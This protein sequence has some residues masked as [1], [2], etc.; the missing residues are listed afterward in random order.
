VHRFELVR[1]DVLSN[2]DDL[3]D[4]SFVSIDELR[5]DRDRLEM[6]SQICLDALYEVD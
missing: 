6:W 4:A 1:P 3:S 5:K 2:E